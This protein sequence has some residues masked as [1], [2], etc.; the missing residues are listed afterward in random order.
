MSFGTILH[1]PK[2]ITCL[3]NGKRI[4]INDALTARNLAKRNRLPAPTFECEEC[5]QRVI[6]HKESSYGHA[7]FEHRKRNEHC[8]QSDHRQ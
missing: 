5:K 3:R 6:A 8:S 4:S 1:M 2:M 7:H